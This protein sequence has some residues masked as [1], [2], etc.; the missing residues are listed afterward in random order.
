V[1]NIYD[2]VHKSRI[3]HWISSGGNLPNLGLWRRCGPRKKTR[4]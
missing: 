1:P 3:T 2:V 4:R